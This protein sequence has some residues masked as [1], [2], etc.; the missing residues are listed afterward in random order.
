MIL[1]KVGLMSHSAF[2]KDS[3]L[4][5][6]VYKSYLI[7]FGSFLNNSQDPAFDLIASLALQVHSYVRHSPSTDNT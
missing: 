4:K 3:L 1:T 2:P 6:Y 5:I 7:R